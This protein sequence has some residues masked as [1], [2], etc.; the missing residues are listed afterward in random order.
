LAIPTKRFP[1]K[2][3]HYE[4]LITA[5]TGPLR[6]RFPEKIKH[7]TS[8]GAQAMA[9]CSSQQLVNGLLHHL[10]LNISAR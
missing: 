1:S 5:R 3:D 9:K 2:F 10:P 4:T 7:V 6:A 8:I